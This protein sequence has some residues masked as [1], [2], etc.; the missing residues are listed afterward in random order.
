[1]VSVVGIEISGR[2]WSQNENQPLTDDIWW[3]LFTEFVE[4]NNLSF[5]GTVSS[6]ELDPDDATT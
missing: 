3:D 5:A 4:D 1:M 6:K 2:F